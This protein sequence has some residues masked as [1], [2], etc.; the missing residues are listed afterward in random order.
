MASDPNRYIVN[1][2]KNWASLNKNVAILQEKCNG[3]L[4]SMESIPKLLQEVM[5]DQGTS[6]TYRRPKFGEKFGETKRKES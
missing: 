4:P 1:G 3:K 2:V 6:G 5:K